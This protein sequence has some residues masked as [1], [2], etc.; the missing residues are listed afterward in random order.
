MLTKSTYSGLDKGSWTNTE[1]LQNTHC[2][3][4][5]QKISL[6]YN[7]CKNCPLSTNSILG[8]QL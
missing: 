1:T 5:S 3:T 7:Y 4:V 6:F 8:R 2:Y